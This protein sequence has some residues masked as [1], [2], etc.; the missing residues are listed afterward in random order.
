M[1]PISLATKFWASSVMCFGQENVVYIHAR[2]LSSVWPFVIS[3]TVA[4]QVPL[5]MGFS[6]QEYWSGKPSPSPGNLPDPG[7][8]PTSPTSL[9]LTGGFFYHCTT[10]CYVNS[11]P[12]PQEVKHP[13][14]FSLLEISPPSMWA[15]S[16]W[17]FLG[18][19]W[20]EIK[21]PSPAKAS[22]DQPTHSRSG[23]WPE[24]HK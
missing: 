21:L 18:A 23:H 7:I 14:L 22:L 17:L 19:C 10:W 3:W 20:T 16:S 2:L 24:M 6:R 12:K 13:F 4:C 8:E 5:S 1:K 15:S 11:E 9:A